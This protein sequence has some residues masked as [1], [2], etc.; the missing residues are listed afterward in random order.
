LESRPNPHCALHFTSFWIRITMSSVESPPTAVRC[1]IE[2]LP[3]EIKTTQPGSG[4]CFCAEL[5]WGELRRWYLRRFR[6]GYV[7]RMARLRR[8]DPA[9]LPWEILDPRDLKFL[10]NQTECQWAPED[11]PFRWRERIPFA[12]WGLAELQLMGW[13]L[14]AL[15][16]A[17]AFTWWYLA[18]LAACVLFLVV[19]FFRDPPRHV[20]QQPGLL[21]AP[22]DG[23]VVEVT[24]LEHDEFVGG[25]AVRI[26]IFL[27]LFNVHINRSPCAARVIRLRYS[28]G[29]FISALNPRCAIENEAM[30]IG[31][32]EDAVP[33]RR[34][35]VR[36]IA[37]Q[38]ARR[39]VCDLR[40]GRVVGRGEKFGMIK[41]GSR[42]ELIVPAD[43]LRVTVSVGQ[44]IRGGRDVIGIYDRPT[45]TDVS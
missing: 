30:W 5:A 7:A 16:V 29:R 38:V 44:T 11:D 8:G 35:A 43:G 34:F 45:P 3:A 37:G 10:R 28:P 39:I 18:P 6:P 12:R 22:A 14:L 1:A 15:T 24:A 2:P 31:L 4:Y 25:P 36:Q 13:P 32:E 33:Y 9:G 40:P 26:A 20:P 27:S 17:L 23:K 21:V 41:L 42:T 19:Y